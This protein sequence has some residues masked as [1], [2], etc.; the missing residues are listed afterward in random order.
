MYLYACWKHIYNI[1]NCTFFFWAVESCRN[2]EA[3]VRI[4]T[5]MSACL[6]CFNL[7]ANAVLKIAVFCVVTPCGLLARITSGRSLLIDIYH[8]DGGSKYLRNVDNYQTVR[9][10]IP[11][12]T[13]LHRVNHKCHKIYVEP[14]LCV[15]C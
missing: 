7:T 1:L 3:P 11:K 2:Q 10:H 13:N 8:G 4:C 12:D 9:S 15:I 6:I 14:F 5:V